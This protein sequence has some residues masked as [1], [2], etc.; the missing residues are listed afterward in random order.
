MVQI[1][2]LYN[3]DKKINFQIKIRENIQKDVHNITKQF[4]TFFYRV[5]NCAYK[6]FVIIAPVGGT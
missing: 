6:K 2:S 5:Y 4:K 1:L 3:S